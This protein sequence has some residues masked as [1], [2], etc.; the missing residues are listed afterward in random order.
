M[1][2][3][4]ARE[5]AGGDR[6]EA[7]AAMMRMVPRGEQPSE[8]LLAGRVGEGEEEG[9]GGMVHEGAVP[10]SEVARQCVGVDVGAGECGGGDDSLPEWSRMY[11]IVSLP[12][13]SRPLLV[14]INA[15]S[16][17]QHGAELHRRFNMLL[18][19]IQ[20]REGEG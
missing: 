2:S 10:G 6:E 3:C 5:G 17:A 1:S 18:N 8:F 14:L 20:A 16:G 9:E 7:E 11:E 13:W 4:E 19:P 12:A 15:K